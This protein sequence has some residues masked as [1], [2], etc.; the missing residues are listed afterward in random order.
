MVA[1]HGGWHGGRRGGRHVQAAC[2]GGTTHLEVLVA[3][4]KRG[5][6]ILPPHRRKVLRAKLV[7]LHALSAHLVESEPRGDVDEQLTRRR[8]RWPRQRLRRRQR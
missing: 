2:A 5:P 1:R 7:E 3:L 4:Q 8:A 6:R